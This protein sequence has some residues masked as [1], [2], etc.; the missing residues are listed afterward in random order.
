MVSTCLPNLEMA[1]A[2]SLLLMPD[3]QH[4]VLDEIT[5]AGYSGAVKDQNSPF[6]LAASV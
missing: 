1:A 5:A 3:K 6:I 2:F 4:D